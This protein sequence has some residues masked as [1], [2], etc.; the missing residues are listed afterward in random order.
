MAT[1]CQ[2][3]RRPLS[4]AVRSPGAA[5]TALAL[6]TDSGRTECTVIACLDSER[7][8][9]TMFILEGRPSE[10]HHLLPALD[11]LLSVVAGQGEPT[12]LDALVLGTSRPGDGT[13]PGHDDLFVWAAAEQRCVEAGLTLLDWFILA[14]GTATSVGDYLGRPSAW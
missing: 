8:P 2:H 13:A 5:L 9:L 11:V 3:H 14:D 1:I 10:H 6:A 4:A 7:R 12:A